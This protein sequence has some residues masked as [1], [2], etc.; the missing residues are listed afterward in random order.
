MAAVQNVG[1]QLAVAEAR[2]MLRG[3]PMPYYEF[4]GAT[5][6]VLTDNLWFNGDMLRDMIMDRAITEF[7]RGNENG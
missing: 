2:Q 5:K 3:V 4:E 7:T 6:Q 1:Q